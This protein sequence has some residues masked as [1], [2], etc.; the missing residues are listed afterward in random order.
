DYRLFYCA[1]V[2]AGLGSTVVRTATLFEIYELTSSPL[3]LGLISLANGLPT[4]GLSLV[5]GV[6]AD[7][8][9]RRRVLMLTQLTAGL[10]GLAVGVVAA[11][12]ALAV[13]HLYALTLAMAT[14]TAAN[15]P[16]R[17]AMIP[18]LVPAE[19]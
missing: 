6:I 9:D 10:L 4:I 1:L 11:S 17:T 8:V 3:H 2:I 19:D 5:G 18:S 14:L 15:G 7:R 16:A 13:W 12:G